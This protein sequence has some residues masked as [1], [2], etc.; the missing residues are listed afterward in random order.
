MKT[1]TSILTALIIFTAGTAALAADTV[2]SKRGDYFFYPVQLIDLFTQTFSPKSGSNRNQSSQSIYLKA[3]KNFDQFE[4]GGSLYYS[5]TDYD[6]SEKKTEQ[7]VGLFGQYNFG[8]PSMTGAVR[9][10]VRM[11]LLRN[12]LTKGTP[13]AP[14]SART[15][16]WFA[17]L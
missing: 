9:K 1:L 7:S 2:S 8:S 3:G 12:V 6:R 11:F 4:V 10:S 13:N 17:R 15:Y 16:H 5:A 14:K